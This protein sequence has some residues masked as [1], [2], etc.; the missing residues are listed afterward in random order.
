MELSPP[1]AQL[2]SDTCEKLALKTPLRFQYFTESVFSCAK[3]TDGTTIN[4]KSI[5][6]IL[7][8]Y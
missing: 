4:K 7:F 5:L 6:F 2:V 8:R 3:S 1:A